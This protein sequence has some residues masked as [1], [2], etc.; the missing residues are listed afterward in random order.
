MRLRLLLATAVTALVATVPGTA[1]AAWGA[2]AGGTSWSRAMALPAGNVPSAV[3][4]NGTIVLAWTASQ[5]PNATAVAGYRI[6]RYAAGG[7]TPET[8][9]GSC[10]GTVSALT[11]TDTTVPTGRWEYTV[12]PRQA[13]WQGAEGGRSAAISVGQ[14]SLSL[15]SSSVASLPT[16]LSGSL[17]AF[18]SGEHVSFRIDDP[19]TGPSLTGSITPDPVPSNGQAALSV[20]IPAGTTEGVHGVYAIGDRGTVA[21]ALITVDTAAPTVGGAVIVKGA[22][23]TTGLLAQGG[24][25]YVYANL[26]DPSG[27]VTATAN[28]GTITTGTTA[29]PLTAGSYTAGGTAYGWRSALLTASSPLAAGSKA[30]SVT[31]TD[32]F[33]HAGTQPGFTVTIDNTAP[34]AADIQTT[35]VGGG[36][37]GK[38][39]SADT[40]VFTFSEPV[41]PGTILAGWNGSSTSVTLRLNQQ[42]GTPGDRLQVWD[43]ANTTQLPFGLIRLFNDYVSADRVF[44][45]ST[46]VMSGS[47]VTVT[48]GSPSGATLTATGSGNISWGPVTTITDAAGNACSNAN[49]TETG[50]ADLDF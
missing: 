4:S 48:L 18:G 34:A 2:S 30:F 41:E 37:A 19:S 24:T 11:C 42:N 22:G 26:S 7:A 38:A 33:A 27:V 8:A 45:G 44:S 28:V 13:A 31:G 17:T 6:T 43:A 36:T 16:S 15:S 14:A 23:G 21:G 1:L 5:L 35:N 25:Y 49:V 3:S 12:T 29:T 46:M 10:G 9:G 50:A 40:V 32:A 47:T 20:T 39:E